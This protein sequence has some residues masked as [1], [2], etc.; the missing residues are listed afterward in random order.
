MLKIA[1]SLIALRAGFGAAA[2]APPER[3]KG[4][5]PVPVILAQV[6]LGNSSASAFD[7]GLADRRAYEEWFASLTGDFKT[8]NIG[9]GNVA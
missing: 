2:N 8:P 1:I 3:I 6:T 9:P 7:A 5:T 4:N